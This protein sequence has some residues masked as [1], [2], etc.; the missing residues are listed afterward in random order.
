MATAAA[1][2]GIYEALLIEENSEAKEKRWSAKNL[3]LTYYISLSTKRLKVFLGFLF[4]SFLV[5]VVF[6][7]MLYHY[8][9]KSA[10]QT[11]KAKRGLPEEPEPIKNF[12]W[13]K[14]K[15]ELFKSQILVNEVQQYANGLLTMQELANSIWRLT[16]KGRSVV[17]VLNTLKAILRDEGIGWNKKQRVS[18]KNEPVG[19]SLYVLSLNADYKSIC[20]AILVSIGTKP[21]I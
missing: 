9:D 7:S 12:N 19:K 21:L 5:L 16:G 8:T 18:V 20:P 6:V 13:A 10:S 3:G 14:A 2:E 17:T 11:R 1:S 15:H 4:C